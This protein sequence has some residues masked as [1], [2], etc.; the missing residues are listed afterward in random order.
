MR[1]RSISKSVLC[2]ASVVSLLGGV[3]AHSQPVE[4]VAS[5]HSEK[6]LPN[7]AA[8]HAQT[9]GSQARSPESVIS[10]T[11]LFLVKGGDPQAAIKLL[12][13]AILSWPNDSRLYAHR[14]V[15][16]SLAKDFEG[17]FAD[18]DTSERLNPADSLAFDFRGLTLF[19]Q[20]DLDHALVAFEGALARNPAD[21]IAFTGRGDIAF[22]RGKFNA[23]LE[24]FNRAV[25]ADPTYAKAWRDSGRARWAM[26]DLDGAIADLSRAIAIQPSEDAFRLRG[27]VWW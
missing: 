21:E 16:R 22:H 8:G 15:I 19:D 1:A 3:P 13:A 23:A 20:G 25:A 24:D 26:S 11:Y 7:D 6:P 10:E 5:A 4:G 2:L 14:G 27:L 9:K 12:D 17:A 18:Y